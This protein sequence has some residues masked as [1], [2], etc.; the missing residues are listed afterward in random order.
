MNAPI[1]QDHA[2]E[3]ERAAEDRGAD[4]LAD[5]LAPL[6]DVE[7]VQGSFVLSADGELLLWD[8]PGDLREET[9]DG[10]APRLAR[11]RDTLAHDGGDV[12]FCMLRFAKNRLCLR[13][14]SACVLAVVTSTTVNVAALRMAM[15][16]TSRRLTRLME[17]E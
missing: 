4:P 8:T 13:A 17:E 1:V 7:G 6:A 11:L 12:D 9:L 2:Q 16:V 14:S 10:V 5:L 15:T 3:R